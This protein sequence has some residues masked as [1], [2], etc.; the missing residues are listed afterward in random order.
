MTGDGVS[1]YDRRA[2]AWVRHRFGVVPDPGS[3]TFET[4]VAAYASGGWANFD[5]T[6]TVGGAPDSRTLDDEAWHYDLSQILRELFETEP[7]SE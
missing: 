3:V 5:V 2:Q 4:D 1:E 6:W 7:L